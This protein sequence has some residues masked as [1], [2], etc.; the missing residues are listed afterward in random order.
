[1]KK[2]LFILF[3]PL[4]VCT[5]TRAQ[6][7]V[8]YGNNPAV[9]R[10]ADVNG[11]RLY[12]EIYGEGH[13]LLLLHGNGGSI[14]GRASQISIYAKKYKVIAV[15]SR[16]HG[17]SGCPAQDLTYE[18]MAADVNALLEQ[19]QIDSLYIWGHSDG[20]I[21]GLIMAF[22]YPK[23]VQKLLASGA[24][25]VADTTAVFPQ[26]MEL[27]RMYPMIPDT[28]QRRRFKLLAEQPHIP[29]D[30]LR[31]ISAPVLVMAGDRDAIREEHT[32]K[33]FQ[34]I[35]NAQLCILP[36]TTHYVY[37]DRPALFNQFLFDFFDKPFTKPSTVEGALQQARQM[38]N[39]WHQ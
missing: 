10:Y 33:I 3:L 38:M 15:D 28:L 14:G 31:K 20:A 18:Q 4:M 21:I 37:A 35:P 36:G 27:V 26:L 11:I 6:N 22:K 7:Q 12:Y 8:P 2:I 5:A 32:V 39:K 30:S 24:N 19:L 16:C 29:F 9:G 1:M 17:K 34:S 13:P 23:K 25:I